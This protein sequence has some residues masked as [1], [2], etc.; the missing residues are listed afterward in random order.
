[1]A[2][3]GSKENYVALHVA[4]DLADSEGRD[5]PPV[6]AYAYDQGG[7][8]LSRAEV[9]DGSADLR[10]P[11]PE[12]GRRIRVMV[13]PD[14]GEDASVSELLRRSARSRW[15]TATIDRPQLEFEFHIVSPDWLCWWQGLCNV[16][17]TVV[18][19]VTI[20]G[21][22]T[23]APVC[24]ATVEVYEVDP[25][26]KVIEAIPLEVVR[27]IRDLLAFPPPPPPD[28]EP[29]DTFPDPQPGE[30]PPPGS[31]PA[32]PAPPEPVDEIEVGRVAAA[33]PLELKQLARALP[34]REFRATLADYQQWIVPLLCF[35]WPNYT[36][37]LVA[38]DT[39]DE[40]GEFSAWFSQGCSSDTPDIYFRVRQWVPWLGYTTIYSPT[41]VPCF[42]RWNY[43]CG[44]EVEIK[45]WHPLALT[46]PPCPD[47]EAPPKHVLAMA[48]GNLRLSE[49][50][51]TSPEAE[52]T[53]AL[54]ADSSLLGITAKGEPFA[55]LCRLHLE[56]DAGDLLPAGITH[57]RVQ[58]R[59]GSSG[60][61][62]DLAGECNRHYRYSIEVDGE[63]VVV[64][65]PYKLGPEEVGGTPNLF[66]IPPVMPPKGVWSLPDK[67]E[68]ST[69]AKF[70]TALLPPVGNPGVLLPAALL[71]QAGKYELK[72]DLFRNDGTRIDGADL[73]AEG[74]TYRVPRRPNSAGI[75][76]TANAASA[77][78]G[79][80]SDGSLIFTLHVDNVPASASI[81]A[82]HTPSATADGSC[83]VLEYGAT[84]DVVTM[85]FTAAHPNG[86]ASY[87]FDV[88]RVDSVLAT[89]E[90]DVPGGSLALA[91]GDMLGACAAQ[92]GGVAAFAE[93]LHVY[94]TATN[95]WG[96]VLGNDAHAVRAFVLSP[97][98]TP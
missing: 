76:H 10:V 7:N 72:V 11:A 82:P 51:G 20:D 55:G 77:P 87:H 65:E 79:L 48:I 56:F 49:I 80:V 26:L 91:V 66:R 73:A 38:V 54:A 22:T 24:N 67:V 31:T 19:N 28:W 6:V 44:T 47:Y 61:F 92:V 88:R 4:V 95:G 94:T 97:Q 21:I 46:C 62:K 81:A 27:D 9:Q 12:G 89:D 16:R 60:Q 84:S 8:L 53:T 39:T 35:Y 78:L 42:T 13:G 15:A 63:D 14:A 36:M 17:G 64:I 5:T 1:M 90:G 74:I 37:Q 2:A 34:A 75:I 32:W 96:R 98:S 83:G 29:P 58:W 43:Q 50:H 57:Y 41:P 18:K 85:P 69:N 68:D 70:P 52:L 45:V 40:C 3:K 33:A 93:H 86:F 23:E 59:K 25:Y 30:P 71:A